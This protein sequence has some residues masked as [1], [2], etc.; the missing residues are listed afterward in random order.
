MGTPSATVNNVVNNV[1]KQLLH[2]NNLKKSK[3][4]MSSLKLCKNCKHFVNNTMPLIQYGKCR[5]NADVSPKVI[6]L[7]DGRVLS[8]KTTYKYASTERKYGPCGE[9]GI[10]Y[11]FEN[12][13]FKRFV[14]CQS[15]T[16]IWALYFA[17]YF[18]LLMIVSIIVHEI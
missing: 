2:L 7:V 15:G 5:L 13:I 8:E 11:E 17:T 16:L 4:K 12:D 3:Q 1:L 10:K 14:N 6:D 9:E 18:T